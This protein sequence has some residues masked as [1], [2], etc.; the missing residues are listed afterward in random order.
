MEQQ[1]TVDEQ[2]LLLSGLHLNPKLHQERAAEGARKRAEAG[3]RADIEARR[4]AWE[5]QKAEAARQE[6]LRVQA[7]MGFLDIYT[8]ISSFSSTDLFPIPMIFFII[9]LFMILQS[10]MADVDGHC[11]LS[12]SYVAESSTAF[13][14]H[15]IKARICGLFPSFCVLAGVVYALLA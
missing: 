8:S 12:F 9:I 15:C 1:S 14:I 5:A 7:N 3:R 2:R 13:E 4:R 6:Q 10:P 11:P